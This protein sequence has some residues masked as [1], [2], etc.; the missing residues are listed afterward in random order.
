MATKKEAAARKAAWTK[1]LAEGRVVRYNVGTM[2]QS[3]ATFHEAH[4]FARTVNDAT[5]GDAVVLEP[6]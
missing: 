1:A 2:F 6:R 4:A 3:F 5:P